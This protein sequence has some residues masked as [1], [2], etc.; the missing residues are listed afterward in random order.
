MID[1]KGQQYASF[2]GVVDHQFVA[3]QRDTAYID[4]GGNQ[5]PKASTLEWK[6]CVQWVDGTSSW[7]PLADLR[8][9]NPVEV[10]E[11]A[12]SRYH[13]FK[14][15]PFAG[16]YERLFVNV[17]GGYAKSKLDIGNVHT[18]MALNRQSPSSKL[19]RLTLSWGQRSGGMQSLR[20]CR[21]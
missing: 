11:Y 7:L 13:D 19:S 2:K 20:Q 10:A 8:E 21:I 18:N 5:Q 4:D 6:L 16:G 3:H 12:I 1:P 17:I 9:S 15:L 14:S